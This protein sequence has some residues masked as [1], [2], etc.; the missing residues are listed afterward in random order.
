MDIA[1]TVTGNENVIKF[2]IDCPIDRLMDIIGIIVCATKYNQAIQTPLG[3]YIDGSPC[4]KNLV[5]AML[6]Q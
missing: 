3:L 6:P 5:G 4:K 1:K 2:T